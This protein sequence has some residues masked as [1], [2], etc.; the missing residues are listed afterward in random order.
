ML[1]NIMFLPHIKMNQPEVYV[2]LLPF[3]LPCHLTPWPT[4]LS[5]HRA[6]DL[7]SLHHT[8]DFHWV[9]NFIY[10]NVYVSM[11]LF[12]FISSSPSPSVSTSLFSLSAS[13]LLSC[14]TIFLD[15]I[16]MCKY[17][18]VFLCLIYTTLFNRL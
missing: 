3:E 17:I 5:C 6:P 8:A 16:Y 12:Q 15:F 18:F 13:L 10:D 7:S 11:L 1:Y 9:S 4:P 14:S 2:C